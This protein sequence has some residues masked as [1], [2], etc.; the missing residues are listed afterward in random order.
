MQQMDKERDKKKEDIARQIYQVTKDNLEKM[1]KQEAQ[2]KG[3]VSEDVVV[4]VIEHNT[5]LV[6]EE[7]GSKEEATKAK[8]HRG[9]TKEKAPMRE[10]HAME[11]ELQRR[12]FEAEA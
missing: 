12:Q 7:T 2:K 5:V 9:T 4:D 10:F 6:V 8:V 11:E 1:E 3:K